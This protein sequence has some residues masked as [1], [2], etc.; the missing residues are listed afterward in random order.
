MH[1]DVL[2]RMRQS[3]RQER[4]RITYHADQEMYKDKLSDLDVE[5]AVLNGRIVD[6]QKDYGSGEFKYL[7]QGK[8]YYGNS[9]IVVAKL[10]PSGWL[11]VVTV[12]R[13]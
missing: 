2:Q 6:R 10:L 13:L 9:I 8:E 3:V 4:Y 12:Y 5:R 1:E 7:I 11:V